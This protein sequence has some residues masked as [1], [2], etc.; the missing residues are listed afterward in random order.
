M[1]RRHHTAADIRA[2]YLANWYY[3]AIV[4]RA[5]YGSRSGMAGLTLEQVEHHARLMAS[6]LTPKEGRNVQATR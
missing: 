1:R 5:A 6:H 4:D 3:R 2:E